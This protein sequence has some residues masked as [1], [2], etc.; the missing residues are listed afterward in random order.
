[1][2]GCGLAVSKDKYEDQE[3]KVKIYGGIWR[4]VVG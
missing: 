3:Y 2:V 1:M 4:C